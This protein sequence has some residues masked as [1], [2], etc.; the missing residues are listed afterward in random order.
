MKIVK[1]VSPPAGLSRFLY[2]LPIYAYRAHLGWAFGERILLLHHLGRVSGKPRQAVLEVAEH[3]RTNDTFVVASGWGA[4]AAW[5]QNVLHTPDVTID[6]GRRTIPVTAIALNADEGADVFAR[7][8][9][10]HRFMAKLALPRVMGFSVDG[11]EADFREAGRHMPFVRF[12]PR[13][14]L[15]SD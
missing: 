5:Y 9:M 4:G 11:S 8:A 2:R 3:D 10:R 1:K 6:V 15:S 14:R 12:V 7:Y 13:P